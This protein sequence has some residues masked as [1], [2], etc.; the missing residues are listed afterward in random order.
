[1]ATTITKLRYSVWMPLKKW[2]RKTFNK[3][4]D[5]DNSPFNTPF[6]IL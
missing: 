5:D 1:M 2:V 3:G 6:A 4:K